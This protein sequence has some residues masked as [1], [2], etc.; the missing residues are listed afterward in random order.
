MRFLLNKTQAKY[1]KER[2]NRDII[3]KARQ[4]GFSSYILADYLVDC[5]RRPTNAIVMSHEREATKRL[6]GKVRYYINNIIGGVRPDIQYESKTEISFPKTNSYFFIGTAGQKAVGRG[7][8]VHRVHCSEIAFWFEPETIMAGI[9]EAVPMSGKLVLE[10]TANGRGTWFYEEWQKAKEGSSIYKPHFYPWFIDNE[11]RMTD[12]QIEILAIAGKT[13]DLILKEELSEEEKDIIAK[14]NLTTEQIRWRRYKIW[15][16][17]EKFYQEYPENDI[18]CFLQSGRPV[19]TIV[20]MAARQPLPKDKLLY[21]GLDPAEGGGDNHCFSIIDPSFNPPRVIFELC[22]NRPYEEFDHAVANVIKGLPNLMLLVEKNGLG[23]AHCQLL[24]QLGIA[25]QEWETTSTT[26]PMMIAELEA[27]YRKNELQETY[28]E[29]K[30]E[31]LDM[32]YDDKN[33]ADHPSKGRSDRVI[34]RAIALQA[35][36]SPIPGI[37]I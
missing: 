27:A 16:L 29:A 28:I 15:D 6:F 17:G 35:M 23:L 18:D 12:E 32:I 3:L 5:C 21:A 34:S 7:D 19:F 37:Y 1:E 8:T 20:N 26:R 25:F 14:Y 30:N 24:K 9:K 36:K 33:R 11:Y 22:N 13:K 10:S 2:T 31:L 4:K